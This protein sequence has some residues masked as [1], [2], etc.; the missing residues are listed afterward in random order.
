ME[1]TNPF[2]V[3]DK[4]YTGSKIPFYFLIL[5]AIV[6]TVR[7]FIHVFAP[8]GGANSIAGIS[9][10]VQGG[11]NIIAIFAQWGAL[12]LLLVLLYWLVIFRYRF[13]VPAMLGVV[14]IEQIFR[15]GAGQLK[16]LEITNPPPGA[17][18]SQIL[19]PLAIIAFIWSLLRRRRQPK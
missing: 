2:P 13:L 17:I 14:V 1:W 4:D 18:G 15:M 19:L 3:V 7:S 9:V 12:Q 11:A 5:V 8:D 10:N 16:P 6:S